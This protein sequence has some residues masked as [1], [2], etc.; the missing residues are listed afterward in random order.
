[1]K[2]KPV[3]VA[4]AQAGA[5]FPETVPSQADGGNPEGLWQMDARLRGHDGI[6]AH[7]TVSPG[8]LAFRLL[9]ALVLGALAAARAPVWEMVVPWIGFV[10]A[11]EG[12]LLA[13]RSRR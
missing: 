6:V 10:L 12:A 7:R 11:V 3:H 1:M 8:L 9:A 2:P 4:P 5:H 13:R